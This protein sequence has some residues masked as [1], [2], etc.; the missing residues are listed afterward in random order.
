MP[1]ARDARPHNHW[2]EA[3]RSQNHY[4]S[5]QKS[6]NRR[7]RIAA[8][9]QSRHSL[10]FSEGHSWIPQSSPKVGAQTYDRRAKLQPPAHV[11]QYF[12]ALQPWEWKLLDSHHHWVWNLE[13]SLWTRN[14]TAEHGMYHTSSPSSKQF[15]TLPSAGKLLLT[16]FWDSQRPILE[17]Y[18]E[19]GITVTSVSYCDL[20][21]DELRPAI[22]S[23]QRGRLLSQ[24]VVLLHDNAR[25][26]K[27]YPT[28]NTIQQLNWKFSSILLTGQIWPFRFPSVWAPQEHSNGSSICRRWRG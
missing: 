27:A 26:H 22:C 5:R 16:V 11:L 19:T 28:F 20:L 21:R 9:H 14:K 23:K 12:G 8:R 6:N 4:S 13:S 2:W 17:Y 25:P 1:S 15:K 3:G 10:V 7:N 18:M 24:R